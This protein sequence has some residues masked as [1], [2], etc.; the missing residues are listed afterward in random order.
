MAHIPSSSL[1]FF[2]AWAL[3]ISPACT[4]SFF[5]IAT[6]MVALAMNPLGRPVD[7]LF[8]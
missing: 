5:F 1:R 8:W 2:R 4:V 3:R 6:T 7:E